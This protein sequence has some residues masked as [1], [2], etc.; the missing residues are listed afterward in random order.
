MTERID[1]FAHVL[2]PRF[3]QSMLK[4]DPQIPQKFPFI[5]IKTLSDMEL[6]RDNFDGM[7]K[8]V[9]SAVNINPEDFVNG[10]QAASL[11]QQANVEIST[12]V[13]ENSDMFHAGIA[14]LPMN[15]VPAAIQ[16]INTLPDDFVGI[17]VFTRANGKSIADAEYDQIFKAA[18]NR[19]LLVLLHPVFDSRK[20][21]NNLVFSWEYELSQAMLELVQSGIYEKYPDLKIIVHHAGA[22]IPYFAGRIDHILPPAQA[23]DFKKFYVD[24]ALLGNAPAL[25][26]AI[27]YFGPDH[28]LFGTDAPF[29]EQPAGATQT[30]I[31]ALADLRRPSKEMQAINYENYQRLVAKIK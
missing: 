3:Y 31:K 22:M 5:N 19:N 27:D 13:A 14:M 28:V 4:I 21:D 2:P 25:Q 17:Q 8:Q 16:I 11:C 1:V 15:N 12:M 6:R 26:L 24:T 18:A 20:P 30:I 10:N 23:D 7:I 9:I 29:A